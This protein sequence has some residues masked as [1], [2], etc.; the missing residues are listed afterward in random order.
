VLKKQSKIAAV[1]GRGI[2]FK[3]RVQGGGY[4]GGFI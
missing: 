4:T 1:Q 2:K 3:I